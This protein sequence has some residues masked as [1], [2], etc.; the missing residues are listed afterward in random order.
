MAKISLDLREA[1]RTLCCRLV[2]D[3]D[4]MDA[5][6]W[7]KTVFEQHPHAREWPSL[8]DLCEY[9][10]GITWDGIIAIA[11]LR[12]PAPPGP[13]NRT[14]IIADRAVY[15]GL[16]RAVDIAYTTLIARRVRLFDTEAA[17]LAWL[18]EDGETG[19]GG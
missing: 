11:H 1:D 18:N 3:V 7:L 6:G 9:E 4:D 13:M 14:A 10:G 2:G 17:A 8:L 16:I 15:D 19:S 5:V 12:G